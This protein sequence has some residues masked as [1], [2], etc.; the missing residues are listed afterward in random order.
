MSQIQATSEIRV[1]HCASC[2]HKNVQYALLC[3][4]GISSKW[5]SSAVRFQQMISFDLIKRNAVGQNHVR[6]ATLNIEDTHSTY[7][8]PLKRRIRR[9]RLFVQKRWIPALQ[10][11]KNRIH[12]CEANE[13]DESCRQ[14]APPNPDPSSL[15]RRRCI[16][17]QPVPTLHGVL[18]L[19]SSQPHKYHSTYMMACSVSAMG[20]V[21]ERGYS[22]SVLSLT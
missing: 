6:S 20:R 9:S 16:P 7:L 15:N 5:C 13:C 14:N 18:E 10:F 8:R 17:L 2:E 11:G 1:F 21:V 4:L 12:S 19:G 3:T 22:V